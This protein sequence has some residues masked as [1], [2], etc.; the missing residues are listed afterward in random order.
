MEDKTIIISIL[1]RGHYRIIFLNCVKSL[2][3][4]FVKFIVST[5]LPPRLVIK[6]VPVILEI[7][8]A[9]LKF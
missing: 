3:G 2:G 5:L 9:A 4:S 8:Y 1:K 6:I 7:A